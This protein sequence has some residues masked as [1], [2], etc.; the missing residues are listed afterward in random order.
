MKLEDNTDFQMA[1]ENLLRSHGI[2]CLM[3]TSATRLMSYLI[4]CLEALES[5]TYNRDR[6]NGHKE[7]GN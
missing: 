2:D 3:D 1:L 5:F 7:Y 4:D 6:E